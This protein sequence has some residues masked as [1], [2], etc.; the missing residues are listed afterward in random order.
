[1]SD[2]AF[3]PLGLVVLLSDFGLADPYVGVMHGVLAQA[4]AALRV[5]DLCHGVP[6]QDVRT[7]AFF[8]AHAREHFP[9]GSM[10]VAVVDPGVGSKRR[11]VAA[12]DGGQLFLAPDN[13]L[14]A[15]AISPQAV[16]RAVD[17]PRLVG[18][19]RSNT[20]HGRD[21]FCPLAAR[22]AGAALRFEDLGPLIDDP[23]R[24]EFPR[25]RREAARVRGEVLLIDGFGNLITSVRPVDLDA[26]PG[27]WRARI[28]AR[29]LVWADSYAQAPDGEPVILVN[30]YGC[31]EVAIAGGSAQRNLGVGLGA[32]IEF[33]R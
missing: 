18:E 22:I 27:A 20:F 33:E 12:C 31:I 5:I 21:V 3:H 4:S 30:S 2:C 11:I 17:V 7:G 8:L 13:G 16:W 29:Q 10:F 28:G 26:A 19:P 1:M 15:L 25:A 23:V 14:L 9:R 32:V 6:A 24:I